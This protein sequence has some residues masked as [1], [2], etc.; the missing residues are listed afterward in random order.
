MAVTTKLLSI[1]RHGNFVPKIR[2]SSSSTTM[3]V[4]I[5]GAGGN[6][7][8][9]VS[10]MLKQSPFIDELCLYDTQSLEGFAN[11]LNYVDTK[12]RVTSFFGNK[13]IQKALTKSNIIVVLSC[14]HA[15][16]PTN[17][18]S[19]FDRNAPI[20]KDLAT[21]IAKFSPKST[22]AI[23]VEPIN[24]VVPMFSEIMKKY[25]HYNPYS[26][27]GITTVDVVRTNKFVAEILGLEPE[28]V[29][30]PIVGGH[31]EKTIV[32]VLSQAK[33]CNELTNEELEDIT[34]SVRKANEHLLKVRSDGAYLASAF[35]VSRFVISLVKAA[36]GQNE[37]VE[38][39]YVKSNVHPQLKYMVT[40]LL[41]G[42]G[43]VAKNLGLPELSDYET[44]LLENAIPVLAEEIKKGEYVGGRPMDLID[45]VLHEKPLCDPCKE[46]RC[47]P[48]HCELQSLFVDK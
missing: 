15:A 37:I 13:D 36:R 47:P 38:C 18:A 42:P 44:C 48:D 14:C 25:G 7:G 22:V 26:I 21:S 35:A 30:V 46:P 28:C 11:D 8:K 31:S 4:T 2:F 5:L 9:S 29:T 19:L 3:K 40:P 17:Y 32:P 20:V 23:G 10:L 34:I 24:S 6:T 43:G 45:G 1:A 16:E 39:S 41:L 27:F 12:C 33:P